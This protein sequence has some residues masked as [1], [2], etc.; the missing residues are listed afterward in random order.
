MG[1]YLINIGDT[2]RDR[3]YRVIHKLGL[4][5]YSTVW[6]AR[7]EKLNRYVAIKVSAADAPASEDENRV[8]T[9]LLDP[10]GADAHPGRQY[11][12]SLLDHFTISEPNGQHACLVTTPA[13]SSLHN[14]KNDYSCPILFPVGFRA[15]AA[16]LI[17][18]VAYI[19]ARD[20]VHGG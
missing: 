1:F 11:V 15:I 17:E 18:A 2:F 5:G 19:H 9:R 6:L 20:I 14:A 4:G 13:R 16:Q 8:L 10:S 3:R 7:D 12:P